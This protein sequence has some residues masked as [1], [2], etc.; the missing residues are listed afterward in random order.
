MPL[1]QFNVGGIKKTAFFSFIPKTGGTALIQAF[2]ALGARIYL[3][4]ENNPVVG[5]LRCPSQHFHYEL[6]SKIIDIGAANHAFAVIRHPLTRAISDYKWAYRNAKSSTRIPWID[7]WLETLLKHYN[8]NGFIF[9]NHLRPQTEFVGPQIKAIYR[10]EDGL[11][12]A[13]IKTLKA[14]QLTPTSDTVNIPR[15]NTSSE[16]M[17]QLVKK[18]SKD[19]LLAAERIVRKFYAKDYQRFEYE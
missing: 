3:H 9:D 1:I 2:R 8:R 11:D 13:L 16:L 14:M 5:V 12:K 15:E 7:D 10:Y 4:E 6:S 19:R 17:T 18:H